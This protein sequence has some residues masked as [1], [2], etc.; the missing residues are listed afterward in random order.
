VWCPFVVRSRVPLM[1]IKCCIALFRVWGFFFFFRYDSLFFFFCCNGVW[2]EDLLLAKQ[3]FYHSSHISALTGFKSKTVVYVCA[4]VCVC[5]HA[6]YGTWI[7][8]L[9]HSTTWAMPPPLLL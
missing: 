8:D 1:F 4:C 9:K 2:T 7:Q 5:V 6:G 3:V